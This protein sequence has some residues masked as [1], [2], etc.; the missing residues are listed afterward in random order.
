MERNVGKE[1]SGVEELYLQTDDLLLQIETLKSSQCDAKLQKRY[2]IEITDKGLPR[3]SIIKNT[4]A[5][6]ACRGFSDLLIIKNWSG[7]RIFQ[8][9]QLKLFFLLNITRAL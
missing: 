1:Q 4:W 5:M 2:Q 7:R 8:I 9:A 3:L 6:K